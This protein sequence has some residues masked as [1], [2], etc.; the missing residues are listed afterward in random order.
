MIAALLTLLGCKEKTDA[1]FGT[2]VEKAMNDLRTKTA[3]HQA[4]WGLGKSERWSLN[5]EDGRLI[6]TFS[7]KMVTCEAQIVGSFNKTKG[8]WLWSWDNPSVMSN[9]TTASRQLRE[10]GRQHGYTKLT[11]AEWKATEEEA[12]EM[13]SIATLESN[14]QGAYRG[15]AGDTYVF[16]TF[17]P[18]K[19]EKRLTSSEANS[20]SSTPDSR[21]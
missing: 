8:T 4:V 5:Q 20:T 12:W 11:R 6:F 14:A 1:G 16:M 19:I 21:R 13:V 7:D 10:Y 9:L 15:P 17:G 18:P 2:L 3:S